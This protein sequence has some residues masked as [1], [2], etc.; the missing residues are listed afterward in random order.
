MK[1]KHILLV[2]ALATL[3]GQAMGGEQQKAPMVMRN[4]VVHQDGGDFG[5]HGMHGKVVKN[6]PYSA[7]AVIERSQALADGN[8]ITSRR[9]MAHYRDGAGR[10]RQE[11]AGPDGEVR[12]IIVHDDKGTL[13]LRPAGK[14]GTR[15]SRDLPEVARMAREHAHEKIVKLRREGKLAPA[16]GGEDAGGEEVVVRRVERF[17]HAEHAGHDGKAM[18]DVRVRVMRDMEGK[19]GE[20]RMLAPMISRAAGDMEYAKDAK[21]TDLG[22]KEI[23][24]V[25]A[26]GK[27]RTYEIPA[28]AIGNEKPI[29]VTDE[30]WFSPELQVTVY[31]KHSDPRS[32]EQVYRLENLRRAEPAG[33]LFA[34]P[35]GY[36]ISDA[37]ERMRQRIE[38]RKEKEK[39][40]EKEKP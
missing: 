18:K 30:S 2:A 33:G 32:G 22:T 19:A 29:V 31:K 5:L 10:T 1:M 4:V 35:S 15:I 6:A 37:A 8:R 38:N 36:T 23:A 21:V 9:S 12:S 26:E 39:E 24:G 25:K 3:S 16:A 20:L 28:G 17:R 40:K 27:M 34:A 7:T 11:V 14:T 13:I